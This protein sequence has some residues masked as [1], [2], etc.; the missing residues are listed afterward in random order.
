MITFIHGDDIVSSR[1]YFLEQRQKVADPFTFEGEKI[2]LLDIIQILEGGG[3]FGDD[4]KIFIENFFSK[5]K[6]GS[7]FNSITLYLKNNSQTGDVYFWEGKE[8]SK[9]NLSIFPHCLVKTFKLPQTLFSFLDNIKPGNGKNL[10][11]LFHKTLPTTEVELI[12]YMLV[13]QFRLLLAVS[14]GKEAE[15]IDEVKRLAPWQKSKLVKQSSYFT[16]DELKR[17]YQKL[18]Q[19]DLAQKTGQSLLSLV[20]SIDFLLLGI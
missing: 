19:I 10:I 18:Y 4:R 2:N 6:P 20:Q 1:K 17:I 7:E 8:V 15:Q 14:S 11:I 12:F 3:L 16:V 9:K 13:R 5:R